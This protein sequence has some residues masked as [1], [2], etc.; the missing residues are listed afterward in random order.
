VLS[1]GCGGGALAAVALL[2]GLIG[3]VV[4]TAAMGARLTDTAYPRLLANVIGAGPGWAA[5]RIRPALILRNE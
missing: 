1:C 5:A 4:L 2:L 3:G